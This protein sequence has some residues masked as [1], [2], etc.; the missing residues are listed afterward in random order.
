MD[1]LLYDVRHSV[2]QVMRRPNFS[3]LAILVVALGIGSATAIFSVFDTLVI[4]ALPYEDADR[5][6]TI[7]QSDSEAGLERSDVAPANFID[8]RDQ[9]ASFEQLA[10]LDPYSLDLTGDERPEVLFAARVSRGFFEAF[11]TVLLYGRLFEPAEYEEYRRVVILSHGLWQRRFGGDP[12]LVGST[13]QLDGEPHTVI[14]ILPP[15]FNPYLHPT[16]RDREAWIPLVFQGW[17]ENVRGS[18]WWNVVGKLRRDATIDEARAEMD[19]ISARLAQDHPTTN[20]TVRANLVPLRDHLVGNVK[21]ALLVLQAAVVF[22]LLIACANVASLFLARGTEREAEFAI[23]GALGAGRLRLL[24]QL[25]TESTVLAVLGGLLGVALAFWSVELM[26]AMGPAELA[27]I[28]EVR[29]DGRILV[30]ALALTGLTAIVAGLV[31]SLHFSRPDLRGSMSEGRT[32]TAGRTRQRIRSGLVVAEVALSL[33]LVVGAGL[34][35]RSFVTLLAVDPGFEKENVAI[36]QVFRYVDDE[37]PEERREFFRQALERI[38]ALPGVQSA[39]AVSAVPFIEANIDIQ[40]PIH[41]EGRPDERPEDAP[42]AFV[43]MATDDY[44]RTMG[45]ALLEGRGIERTDVADAPPVIVLTEALARRH[46]PGESPIGERVRIG[47]WSDDEG[48]QVVWEV[49]GVVRPVRHDGLD[50]DPRPELFVPHAQTNMGSMSFVART[51]GDARALLA[52]MQKEI[53]ELDPLQTFYRVAT[54]KELVSRSTAARRFNLWL[55]ATFAGLALIIAAV[56]IYGVVSYSTRARTHEFG[57]RMALGADN[58]EVLSEAMEKGL[59]LTGLG[60]AL[61]LAGSL[62]LTR[63]MQNLLFGVSAR[64]PI[65]FLVVGALLVAVALAATYLPARRATLVDPAVAL[66]VE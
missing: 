28:E 5:I 49:V 36:T 13:I 17:E 1:D 54:L 53:W 12:D 63:L 65:T 47:D 34:L 9:A 56:G 59:R 29:V 4:R 44:F 55:L 39:G 19:A 25:F 26:V 20:K 48:R 51:E 18:A 42:N 11:G 50:R 30:F 16:V 37:T 43:A 41:I 66:R 22:L 33:V 24:R 35:V 15:S 14:G 23:R 45:I 60:V 57:I 46:W 3:L 58:R 27:R 2:R 10:A 61:G 32:T 7:W 8:W 31:P 40:Q 64:D 38:R 6:I 62:G 52:P 21:T